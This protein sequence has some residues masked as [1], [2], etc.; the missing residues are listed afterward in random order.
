MCEYNKEKKNKFIEKNLTK[1]PFIYKKPSTLS[2]NGT[3][4]VRFSAWLLV[5]IF[6]ICLYTK[7]R[8]LN[9]THVFPMT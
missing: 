5:Q 3:F 6:C 4:G 9:L 2:E 7:T 1:F 8:F